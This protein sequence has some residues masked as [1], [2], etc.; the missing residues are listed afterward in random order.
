ML[1]KFLFSLVALA[2]LTLSAQGRVVLDSD[3]KKVEVPDTIERATPMIGAFVQMSAMLGNEE[4]IISGASRLP[5]LMKKVFPKIRLNDNQS[6][7]LGSSV[8]TL[9]A[10]NTQVVFGPVGMGFDDNAMRQLKAAKISVVKIDKFATAEQIKQSLLLIADIFGAESVKK[11]REFNAYFDENINF[12]KSR[13][14][15]IKNKKRILV[16]NF[17]SGNYSTI[18]AF[19]IGAEYIAMAGGVNLS[20]ELNAKDFKLSQTMNEE[21]VLIFDPDII[22]TSANEGAEVIAKNPA[23]AKFKAVKNKQIFVVPSGVYLWSVRSAEGAL[24]PLWLAKM[25]YPKLFKDLNLEAKVREFYERFYNYKLSE[26]ELKGIL[27][28]K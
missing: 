23:F 12:V 20:S 11:A 25:F 6:G 22:V 19:D 16:L 21:Q 9:I 26:S 24:Y 2:L 4:R 18:S 15:K 5:P 14:E 8:E 13:T 27:S 3:G 28:P 7:M 17:H 1:K 10:S